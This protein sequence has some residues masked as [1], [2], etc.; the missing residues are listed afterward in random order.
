MG[1]MTFGE[2]GIGL[3]S[4]AAALLAGMAGHGTGMTPAG[5]LTPLGMSGVGD[6]LGITN[7]PDLQMGGTQIDA[8]N[9][10]KDPEVEREKRLNDVIV[11]LG[12]RVAGLGVCRE[13]VERVAQLAG[14][15]CLW[16]DDTLT[17][18]G[19]SVDL[20]ID[21]FPISER[22]RD[23]SLKIAMNAEAEAEGREEASEVLKGDLMHNQAS[24]GWKDMEAFSKNLERLGRLDKL[25]QGNI[26]CFE[27]VEGLYESFRKIWSEEKKRMEKS[28][29][30]TRVSRGAI[31]RSVMHKSGRIGLGLEY[32]ATRHA[33]I[34]SALNVGSADA[35]ETDDDTQIPDQEDGVIIWAG[36]VEFETGYPSIRVSKEWISLEAL[37]HEEGESLADALPGAWLDPPAT[38]ASKNEN[39]MDTGG[40][41]GDIGDSV[42]KP[43]NVR[44][45][46][47]LEPILLLPFQVAANIFNAVGIT[48]P[49]DRI[50]VKDIQEHVK[51]WVKE[52]KRGNDQPGA[53]SS[54]WRKSVWTIKKDGNPTEGIY[55]MSLHS[56]G[57]V[58]CSSIQ[59]IYFEH[60]RQIASLLPT[61]RQYAVL[62]TLV[63]NAITGAQDANV[64]TDA[65]KGISTENVQAS[66][67]QGPRKRNN[68][69]QRRAKLAVLMNE[70]QVAEVI[71]SVE[72]TLR[73]S[74][75]HPSHPLLDLRFPL[76]RDLSRLGLD[77][78][79]FGSITVEIGQ[80]G[81]VQVLR[82]ENLPFA[83]SH[84][85]REKLAKVIRVSEDLVMT[86][87]R[88]YDRL[89]EDATV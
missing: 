88:V 62:W 44:F 60:P 14:F 66:K 47:E 49:Q 85:E 59:S 61:F 83:Q 18:A 19:N 50:V 55:N 38:L 31:G 30:L 82:T 69:N 81:H 48:L 75:D 33:F 28:G 68:I 70:K 29:P 17:I 74:M 58:W 12:A 24:T 45:V 23:V 89:E 40:S 32:W 42:P 9:T 79:A 64:K 73:F 52:A 43:P 51:A 10:I 16:Q 25:S 8:G 26:N 27:A 4:P 53:T 11:S 13:A 39:E 56:L 67:K 22:V 71:P 87:A 15:T 41:G 36:H 63:R 2:D 80:N 46:F 84:D 65:S 86:V 76:H 34:E 21:F 54:V 6:G 35:M 7:A 77:K 1:N 20:E 3:S 5:G 72:M 57:P 37:Q 78:P